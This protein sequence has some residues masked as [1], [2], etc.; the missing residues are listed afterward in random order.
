MNYYDA[1]EFITDSL[2]DAGFRTVTFGD[3]DEVDLQRE[4]IYPLAHITPGSS[5]VAVQPFTYSFTIITIDVVSTPKGDLQNEFEPSFG[6]DNTQDVLADIHHK[7]ANFGEYIR[8]GQTEWE[9][10]SGLNLEPFKEAW[11]QLVSGWIFELTISG[12]NYATIC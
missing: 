9:F 5:T 1:I 6:M 11:E 10:L 7:A 8:R 12:A 4:N 2:K 3:I